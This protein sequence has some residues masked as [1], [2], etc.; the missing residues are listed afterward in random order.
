MPS[1]GKV[2]YF[3]CPGIREDL[4]PHVLNAH[5][6]GN[7]IA[8]SARFA[9][10]KDRLNVGFVKQR[11]RPVGL[12]PQTIFETKEPHKTRAAGHKERK[13]ACL[14][15]VVRHRLHPP[16]RDPRTEQ[17]RSI[18]NK[19]SLPTFARFD[20][21]ASVFDGPPHGGRGNSPRGKYGTK[22]FRK[23]V[24]GV[25]LRAAGERKQLVVC[26]LAVRDDGAQVWSPLEQCP[27]CAQNRS[28]HASCEVKGGAVR[29][30]HPAQRCA[31]AG[32]CGSALNQHHHR[33]GEERRRTCTRRQKQFPTIPARRKRRHE[34]DEGGQRGRKG[35]AVHQRTKSRR[36]L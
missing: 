13:F 3:R 23:R 9:G 31:Y 19:N 24:G 29:I 11:D 14:F 20:T 2:R 28:V 16:Q 17:K 8:R 36:K 4:S 35:K 6:A 10:E 26:H 7:G 27:T 22:G 32:V 33:V 21:E 1:F 34:S 5:L 12:R 25:A 18:S 15:E 30:R